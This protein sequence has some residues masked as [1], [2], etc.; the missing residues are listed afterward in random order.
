MMLKLLNDDPSTPGIESGSLLW[1]A[2]RVI[3]PPACEI[4][5]RAEGAWFT[6][7]VIRIGEEVFWAPAESAR[8]TIVF[9]P[10][11]SGIG[12]VNE[13]REEKTVNVS[14][15]FLTSFTD[16]TLVSSRSPL[17]VQL[18]FQVENGNR[19]SILT[20]PPC[21]TKV[22]VSAFVPARRITV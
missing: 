11:T 5:I 22:T 18:D 15:E 21:V 19:L 9:A 20:K 7:R 13:P 12:Y 8:A 14:V 2:S 16:V 6:F 4:E 3:F 1:V 17:S 10:S